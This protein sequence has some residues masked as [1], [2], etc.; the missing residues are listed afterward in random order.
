MD[1]MSKI[2][3]FHPFIS[4][5]DPLPVNVLPDYV[6]KYNIRKPYHHSSQLLPKPSRV[7]NQSLSYKKTFSNS[8]RLKKFQ[9]EIFW[10]LH[11]DWLK[12]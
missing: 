6:S 11:P 10:P 9:T 3:K 8:C 1:D 5:S 2:R 7:N 12:C 4:F